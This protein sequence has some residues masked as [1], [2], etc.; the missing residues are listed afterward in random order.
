MIYSGSIITVQKGSME[1]VKGIIKNYPQIEIFGD[2]KKKDQIVV[3][4]EEIGSRELEALCEK[5]M[6][7]PE[8]IEV[9][10]TNFY[11]GDEVKN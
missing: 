3:T 8:I 4:I 5:L 2:E 11:F 10:H 1:E 7:C 6:V 9:S